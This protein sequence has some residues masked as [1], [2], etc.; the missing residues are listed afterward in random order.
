MRSWGWGPGLTGLVPYKQKERPF[1]QHAH[2]PRKACKA[3]CKGELLQAWKMGPPKTKPAGNCVLDFQPPELW[4]INFCCLSPRFTVSC[5][6]SLS[7]L[8]GRGW[9]SNDPEQPWSPSGSLPLPLPP[10]LPPRGPPGLS[11]AH[12]GLFWLAFP[13][14]SNKPL[15]LGRLWCCLCVLL[16]LREPKRG[17][18][19][20]C[21]S[22]CCEDDIKLWPMFAAVCSMELMLRRTGYDD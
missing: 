12:R 16:R 21:L 3:Q 19:A 8:L 1:S 20:P 17:A 7:R 10:L 18:S 11:Q 2:S 22:A 6:G 13:H 4:E 14:F 15:G 9:K 5:S